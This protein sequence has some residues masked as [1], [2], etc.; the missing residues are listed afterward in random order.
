MIEAAFRVGIPLL[1]LV[2]AY[3]I[4]SAV[5]RSHYRSLRIRESASRR[6]PT[7]NFRTPP[8][9]WRIESS[10]LVAGNVVVSIDYFKRFLA[11]LRMLV[12]GRVASYE[13]LLDRGRREAILRMKEEAF[14]R[15]YNAVI[16]VRIETSRLASSSRNGEGTAGVEVLA[17]GTALQLAR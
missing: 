7:V 17:F 16:N 8:R 12:G 5:E 13:S 11:G 10:E 3:L 2:G 1:L 14:E 4:G 15:G 6:F 9:S